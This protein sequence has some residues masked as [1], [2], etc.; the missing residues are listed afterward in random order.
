MTGPDCIH[1]LDSLDSAQI[2]AAER[3]HVQLQT[4]VI[5]HVSRSTIFQHPVSR[6]VFPAV[7]VT[8]GARLETHL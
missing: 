3:S 4:F 5:G 7:E 1:L 2:E 8:A 6:V